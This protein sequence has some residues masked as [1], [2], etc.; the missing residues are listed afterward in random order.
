MNQ[1]RDGF[2]RHG[3]VTGQTVDGSI[4][5]KGQRPIPQRGGV[6]RPNVMVPVFAI[7]QTARLTFR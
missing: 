2:E 4:C 5:P 3:L 1:S 7:A 6:L